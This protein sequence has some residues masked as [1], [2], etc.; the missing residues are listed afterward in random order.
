MSAGLLPPAVAADPTRSH[1]VFEWSVPLLYGQTAITVTGLLTWSPPP[2]PA[3]VWPISVVLALAGAAA[4]LLARRPRP[5]GAL[6]LVAG[7]A[8]LYHAATTPEPPV[9]VGSHAWALASALLPAL[10][11]AVVAALGFRAA[12][13]GR[14][15]MTGLLAVVLGWLLLVQGLPDVD[16]LWSAH[17]LSNGPDGLARLAVEVLVALGAGLVVGGIATVR[18]TPATAEWEGVDSAALPLHQA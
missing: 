16:V 17:V 11:A 12:L 1:T 10:V 13:R 3:L 9:T 2:S 6:M 5:L 18:R 7:A 4:G 15:S 8:A 14:G